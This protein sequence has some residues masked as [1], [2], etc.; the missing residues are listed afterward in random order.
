MLDHAIFAGRP[1]IYNYRVGH[2]K[3]NLQADRAF[4]WYSY[5]YI[6]KIII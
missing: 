4:K 6:R 5:H 2:Y 3:P 1:G